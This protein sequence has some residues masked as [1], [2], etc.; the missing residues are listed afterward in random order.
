MKLF[1]KIVSFIALIN[2]SVVGKNTFSFYSLEDAF[3]QVNH[4]IKNSH[5][6]NNSPGNPKYVLDE[7][8]ENLKGGQLKEEFYLPEKYSFFNVS[9]QCKDRISQFFESLKNTELW[10]LQSKLLFI[11]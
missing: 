2:A 11:S 9:S 3:K 6:E 8:Y 4:L 5:V 7:F 10:S 1:L